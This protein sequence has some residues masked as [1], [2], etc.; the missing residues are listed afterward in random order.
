MVMRPTIN[1]PKI[2][3]GEY[4]FVLARLSDILY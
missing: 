2:E 4:A 1:R 3:L